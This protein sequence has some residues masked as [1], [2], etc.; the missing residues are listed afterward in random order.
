MESQNKPQTRRLEGQRALVTGAG[1]GIGRAV[2][3]ELAREG[4]AVVF[5]YAHSGKGAISAADDRT[6][7]VWDLE[8]G[9]A[10]RTLAGHSSYVRAVAVTPDG[11]RAVSAS[12]DRT[13]KVWEL[14]SGACLATYGTDEPIQACAVARGGGLII[15]GDDSGRVH[16]LEWAALEP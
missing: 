16:F 12:F 6:L 15:A 7:R 10:M 4:A 9:A 3:L 11:K 5:H 13:L 1:T 14:E 2:G 8:T